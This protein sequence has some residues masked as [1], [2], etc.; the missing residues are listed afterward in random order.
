MKL[1]VAL[2]QIPVGT[3]IAANTEAILRGIEFAKR[4]KAEILL[5]PEGSLSGYWREFD[6][7]LL[8]TALARV[9]DA[10]KDAGLGLALGTC[11]P[12]RDGRIHNQ[13]RF[14][15]AG[16]SLIGTH[17]KILGCCDPENPAEGEHKDYATTPLKTLAFKGITIGG[18]ICN[19]M[20]G[21]P[22]YTAMPNPHLCQQHAAAG[23]RIVFHSVNGGRDGSEWSRDVVWPY[24]ESNLRWR[25]RA[26]KVWIVTVDNCAP[27]GIPCSAPSGV[28]DPQGNWVC[29]T[30][31]EGEQFACHTINLA[32]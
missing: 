4:G 20:W 22:G 18:L 28:I 29:K 16:G 8:Q 1:R 23:A 25:A 24:H 21:S 31:P 14:Y 13:Q 15:D 27:L 9:V 2:A 30:D 26:G 19:D 7:P 6:R 12:D 32:D 3:D 10:A 17:S 5:T 11:H